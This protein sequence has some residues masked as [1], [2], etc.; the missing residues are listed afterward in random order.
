MSQLSTSFYIQVPRVSPD[1]MCA[2]DQHTTDQHHPQGTRRTE[3][4]TRRTET[5]TR[6]AETRHRGAETGDQGAQGTHD[7]PPAADRDHQQPHHQ[8]PSHQ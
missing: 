5:R 8:Q 4:R 3:T 7:K 1:Q 6:R 2:H